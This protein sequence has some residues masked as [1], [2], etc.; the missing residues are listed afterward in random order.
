[1]IGIGQRFLIVRL[2]LS[3]I[4]I[5]QCIG[6]LDF[7]RKI[8]K[9]KHKS[10]KSGKAKVDARLLLDTIANKLS[11]A[12]TFNEMRYNQVTFGDVLAARRTG[13]YTPK[14]A[15]FIPNLDNFFSQ[16]DWSYLESLHKYTNLS[17]H[18][19]LPQDDDGNLVM[20]LP[21]KFSDCERAERIVRHAQ[22]LWEDEKLVVK[23]EESS[24]SG[25]SQ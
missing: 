11:E 14:P 7:G 19:L 6:N 15:A 20:V 3:L 8:S 25:G 24:S 9:T 4:I 10:Y 1:V 17:L 21:H 22:L 13:S 5:N 18:G 12:Y 2:D 23:D 16:D